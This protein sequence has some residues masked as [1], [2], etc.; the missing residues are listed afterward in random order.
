MVLASTDTLAF[1]VD[2]VLIALALI[3]FF[4]PS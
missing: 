4:I 3:V 1:N 2:K